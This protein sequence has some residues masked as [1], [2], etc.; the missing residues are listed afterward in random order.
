[1]V[2]LFVMAERLRRLLGSE[3][4]IDILLYTRSHKAD[5]ILWVQSADRAECQVS[6]VRRTRCR[7]R[8]GWGTAL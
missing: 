6:V 4:S 7:S 5:L 1:V 8:E 2:L 3:L